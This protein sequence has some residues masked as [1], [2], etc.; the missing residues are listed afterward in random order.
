MSLPRKRKKKATRRPATST[1]LKDPLESLAI[2]IGHIIDNASVKDLS[3][4]ALMAGLAYYGGQVFG[5]PHGL[6]AG[7]VALKLATNPG[8]GALGSPAQVAGLAMLGYMGLNISG[9]K[10]DPTIF[11]N[12]PLVEEGLRCEPPLSDIYRGG[13]VRCRKGYILH[14]DSAGNYT[15][16]IPA[17]PEEPLPD[18]G[19][20][21]PVP[22]P[23]VAGWGSFYTDGLMI[24]QIHYCGA[25]ECAMTSD[26]LAK[27]KSEHAATHALPSNGVE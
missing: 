24:C 15:C 14:Q 20:D 3:E 1:F 7:P 26:Q 11:G 2:H 27:Q 16:C 6:L 5:Y 23:P 18:P 21:Y 17:V 19:R 4:L 25:T 12:I 22:E 9:V 10:E 13:S 8:G